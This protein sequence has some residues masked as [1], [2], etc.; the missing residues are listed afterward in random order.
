MGTLYI[1]ATPIGNMGDLTIRAIDVLQTVD[2]IAC[3]D[4]RRTGVLLKHIRDTYPKEGTLKPQLISYYE[5]NEF[6]RIA[7]IVALLKNGQHVALVSDAGTPLVSDPGY[8][9]VHACAKEGIPMISLPGASSVLTALTI[10]GLPSDKFLF[11]GYPPHKSGNR[12]KLFESVKNEPLS[13]TIIFLEAPHKVLKTLTE[14][15]EVVGD[16]DI[17]I[18]R[19]LTKTYEEVRREKISA[20]LTHFENTT[21]KGEFTILFH[22]S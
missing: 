6:R 19:E 17:V 18:C 3:E 9:L 10:S 7:E 21:P 22:L 16:V 8:R 12:K 5:Q 20:S 14:L 1:V 15:Q 13:A 2:I 11:V 4:T